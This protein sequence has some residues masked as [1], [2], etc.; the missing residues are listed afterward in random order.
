MITYPGASPKLDFLRWP[1]S[2]EAEYTPGLP[3]PQHAWLG[4]VRPWMS[5]GGRDCR[6]LVCACAD[7]DD[8]LCHVSRMAA[9][10]SLAIANLLRAT[11]Q[12]KSW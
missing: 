12:E 4:A 11:F 5:A 8:G 9:R 2:L 7:D 1:L 6:S 3:A 10:T